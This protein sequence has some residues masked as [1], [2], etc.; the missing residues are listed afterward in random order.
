LNLQVKEKQQQIRK[1]AQKVQ[2]LKS[3][4]VSTQ[5]ELDESSDEDLS[6]SSATAEDDPMT[7]YRRK[8]RDYSSSTN[9]NTP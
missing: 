1:L 9:S 3:V 7:G 8:G 2:E 4:L 5:C 6:K